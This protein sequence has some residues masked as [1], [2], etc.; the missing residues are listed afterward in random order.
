MELGDLEGAKAS[1]EAALKLD[2]ADAESHFRM[3]NLLAMESRFT[4]AVN[5]WTQSLK[6]RPDDPEAHNNLAI[7]LAQQGHIAE[8]M[9]HYEA[10][11]RL[12]P[13]YAT[14]RKNL[15]DLRL[16]KPDSTGSK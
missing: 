8:A 5:E 4:E 9:S 13:D 10:A 6:L 14:A 11:L 3:G 15:E 2:P 16:L 1:F 12:K 7:A